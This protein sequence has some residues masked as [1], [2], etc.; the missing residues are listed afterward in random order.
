M[1]V[2]LA[3]A[4]GLLRWL[5]GVGLTTTSAALS[6]AAH[7]AAGGALP[8]PGVT[9]VI[10]ALLASAGVAL[11]DRQ[12]GPL[13]ILSALA[14]NQMA[15]HVFFQLSGAHAAHPVHPAT[16]FAPVQ[17]AFGHIASAILTGLLLSSAER[18]LFG[19][20]RFLRRVLPRVPHR[21]PPPA[22]ETCVACIPAR[23]RR[24]IAQLTA[25]R[26]HALRGPPAPAR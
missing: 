12:R 26:I 20:A 2:Q 14:A 16:P 19:V 9:A 5:R 22:R 6:V 1:S 25:Q 23:S 21:T 15:F 11:A 18:A 13:G 4:Q 8:D 3:P 17:M 10:T 7:A 24:L